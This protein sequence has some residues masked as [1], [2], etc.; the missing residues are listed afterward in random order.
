MSDRL[1]DGLDTGPVREMR[2]VWDAKFVLNS[3]CVLSADY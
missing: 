2:H 1:K 3:I